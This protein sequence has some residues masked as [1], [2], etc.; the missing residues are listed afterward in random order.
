MELPTATSSNPDNDSYRSLT[1]VNEIQ[2]L[3]PDEIP[4]VTTSFTQC[5]SFTSNSSTPTMEN[6]KLSHASSGNSLYLSSLKNS[7]SSNTLNMDDINDRS[8]RPHL[9]KQEKFCYN[10]VEDESSECYTMKEKESTL[11]NESSHSTSASVYENKYD[12]EDSDICRRS[13]SES[14]FW[15]QASRKNSSECETNGRHSSPKSRSWKTQDG[16]LDSDGSSYA[17]SRSRY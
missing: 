4:L 6:R 2:S 7:S 14:E 11:D 8:T 13:S 1:P 10:N 16:R 5:T 12:Q 17:N 15:R 3:I 9:K